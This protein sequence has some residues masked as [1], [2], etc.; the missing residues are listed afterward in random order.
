VYN[1]FVRCC[2]SLIPASPNISCNQDVVQQFG[3]LKQIL[4]QKPIKG[5]WE[6]WNSV[7]EHDT[8]FWSM[9]G[10]KPIKCWSEQ[11]NSLIEHDTDFWSM[12]ILIYC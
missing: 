6:Q 8:D 7:I 10:L 9:L 11:R 12:L 5:W 4:G 3:A 1:N 2:Q